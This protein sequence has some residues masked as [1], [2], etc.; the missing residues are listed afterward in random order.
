M[1]FDIFNKKKE[2]PLIDNKFFSNDKD[3]ISQY[4]KIEE[5][6][7]T[8]T[9][10]SIDNIKKW[11]EKNKN[12]DANKEKYVNS[13]RY[14]YYIYL[15]N[16]IRCITAINSPFEFVKIMLLTFVNPLKKK[17]SLLR[18]FNNVIGVKIK[19][20]DI[21]RIN[22]NQKSGIK[23]KQ[24]K[25]HYLNIF[26]NNDIYLYILN[27]IKTKYPPKYDVNKCYIYRYHNNDLS[28][29]IVYPKKIRDIDELKKIVERIYK[30]DFSEDIKY[31]LIKQENYYFMIEMIVLLDK[32]NEKYGDSFKLLDN[33]TYHRNTIDKK[34]DEY[35]YDIYETLKNFEIFIKQFIR[36]ND[37]NKLSK[38]SSKNPSKKK[39]KKLEKDNPSKIKEKVK[40]SSKKSVKIDNK[41][42]DKKLLN[43]IQKPSKTHD[44]DNSTISDDS[45]DDI[46]SIDDK[47]TD[48]KE[49][50][51][52]IDINK[53]TKIIDDIK[54][55]AITTFIKN[56]LQKKKDSFTTIKTI[57]NA[58][59]KSKVYKNLAQTNIIIK[60]NYIVSYLQKYKWF[61][62]NYRDMY[63]NTRS[64]IL[65]YTLLNKHFYI[66]N[67]FY[68]KR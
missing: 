57:V 2:D 39:L 24:L 65:N 50:K 34:L 20:K 48:D 42:D 63:K 21:I 46:E 6:E 26:T 60:R 13:I 25:E 61:T 43:K 66:K 52:K 16:D 55:K 53:N 49:N 44:S 3:G 4:K 12:I 64:V 62:D 11:M 7:Y 22:D 41:D 67:N 47:K 10:K 1:E 58:F 56:N 23:L 31:D 59:E 40:K 38:K 32:Y 68:I 14:I 33:M 37:N 17:D 5:Y 15:D 35:G 30:Y 18:H 45:E 9:Q 28:R 29:C 8:I 36:N 54:N 27:I 19:L 51:K